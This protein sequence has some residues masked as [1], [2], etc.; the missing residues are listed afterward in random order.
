MNQCAMTSEFV[1]YHLTHSNDH[2]PDIEPKNVSQK[3]STKK[4]C[5]AC[6]CPLKCRWRLVLNS[7]LQ[8]FFYISLSDST[9]AKTNQERSP[10]CACVSDC[11]VD[12]AAN[13]TNFFLPHLSSVFAH[14]T[15]VP[16][17]IVDTKL[18]TT[19]VTASLPGLFMFA[20]I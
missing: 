20:E 10:L 4:K 6:N 11:K 16:S 2:I 5:R 7:H 8:W 19:T 17:S 12:Q 13:E 3:A 9:I 18:Q 14:L 15:C 1:G